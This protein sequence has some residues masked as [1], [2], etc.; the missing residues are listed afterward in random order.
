MAIR[1]RPRSPYLPLS[2]PV[3]PCFWL[4]LVHNV[5][6]DAI[7]GSQIGTFPSLAFIC[8]KW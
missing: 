7:F 6:V 4:G 2:A 8:S 1:R 5:D 3:C